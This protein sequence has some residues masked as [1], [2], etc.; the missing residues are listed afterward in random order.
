MNG[1]VQIVC[2]ECGGADVTRDAVARWSEPSQK[3][4]LSGTHDA[5]YCEDCDME[6]RHVNERIA[7]GV[8]A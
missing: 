3:W 6:L 2:P 8:P 5:F 7:S 1:P 4:V